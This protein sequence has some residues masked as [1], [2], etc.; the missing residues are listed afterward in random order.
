[1]IIDL[2]SFI[3]NFIKF[4]KRYKFVRKLKL[5]FFYIKPKANS[6]VINQS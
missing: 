2:K 4:A 1:M 5:N 6:R 3:S